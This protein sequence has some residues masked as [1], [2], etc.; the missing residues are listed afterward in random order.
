MHIPGPAMT[1]AILVAGAVRSSILPT[2]NPPPPHLQQP[3][4]QHLVPH[5]CLAYSI[6]QAEARTARRI[7]LGPL[8][9]SAPLCPAREAPLPWSCSAKPHHQEENNHTMALC[10]PDP[11]NYCKSTSSSA[12]L[13]T[14]MYWHNV[15]QH[16][17]ST[18]RHATENCA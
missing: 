4:Q 13:P 17:L 5:W 2:T 14:P 10:R 1:V 12:T 18:N 8:L 9:P 3:Q 11:S 6:P 16:Y 7:A 15:L